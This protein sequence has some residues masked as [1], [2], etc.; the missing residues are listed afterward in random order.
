M[1]DDHELANDDE[2]ECPGEDI[3]VPTHFP[4]LPADA[5]IEDVVAALLASRDRRDRTDFEIYVIELDDDRL[6]L[7]LWEKCARDRAVA[8]T[9][10][11]RAE[12]TRMW[13]RGRRPRR[14]QTVA[15]V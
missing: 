5:S 2:A 9:P 7:K 4:E 8:A 14:H 3:P 11:D 13:G 6:A 1:D 10:A 12:A 15:P